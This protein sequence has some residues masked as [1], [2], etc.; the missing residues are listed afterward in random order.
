MGSLI[1]TAFGLFT[2]RLAFSAFFW[3]T[4]AQKAIQSI[5]LY[6]IIMLMF[7]CALSLSVSVYLC[8][9]INICMY[10]CMCVYM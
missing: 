8:V 4:T 7:N 10:V 9:Y 3:S 6:G 2:F 5:A 1:S